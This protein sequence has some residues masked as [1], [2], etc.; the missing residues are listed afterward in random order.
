MNL[1]S[2]PASSVRS[3][4]GSPARCRFLQPAAAP[5]RAP[6]R[7]RSAPPPDAEGA[8]GQAAAAPPCGGDQQ[9]SA[10]AR[11]QNGARSRR[12]QGAR[13]GG[14]DD[15][16]QTDPGRPP[17]GATRAVGLHRSHL[18]STAT[19]PDAGC[20]FAGTAS[21]LPSPAAL[22]AAIFPLP[23]PPPLPA[24]APLL[25]TGRRRV[26]GRAPADLHRR[27]PRAP[28]PTVTSKDL[29]RPRLNRSIRLPPAATRPQP[30]LPEPSSPVA[31]LPRAERPNSLGTSR[32]R[33][34]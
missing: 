28:A 20:Q 2:P 15:C 30:R 31:A 7:R 14:E 13:R 11:E 32:A 3:R 16:Q 19:Q 25:P 26:P 9:S 1:S 12:L 17:T 18:P 10:A 5:R 24:A 21:R 6:A 8:S 22:G 33:A 27:A 29:T 23:L 4:A 34:G